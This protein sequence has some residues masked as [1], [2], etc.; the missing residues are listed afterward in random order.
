LSCPKC[1]SAKNIICLAGGIVLT[2]TQQIPL[3]CWVC[4]ESF[5]AIKKKGLKANSEYLSFEIIAP[6]QKLLNHNISDYGSK[7]LKR[8][9]SRRKK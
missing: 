3:Y 9:I 2:Q 4:K 7:S 8:F 1:N 5:F 6:Y